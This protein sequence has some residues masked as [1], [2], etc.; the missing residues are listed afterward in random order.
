MDFRFSKAWAYIFSI[1][2]PN[3]LIYIVLKR[4]GQNINLLQHY[5]CHA[6]IITH[7]ETG[8]DKLNL[9]YNT[10]K[11]E[12]CNQYKISYILKLLIALNFKTVLVHRFLPLIDYT[13]FTLEI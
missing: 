1:K 6:N 12:V 5:A 10:R 7:I 4:I 9:V 3:I 11:Y 13:L 8:L 2:L